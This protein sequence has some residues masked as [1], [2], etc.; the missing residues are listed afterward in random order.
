MTMEICLAAV[1]Q[2]DCVLMYVPKELQEQVRKEA[3]V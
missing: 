2:E 1:Q 3:E